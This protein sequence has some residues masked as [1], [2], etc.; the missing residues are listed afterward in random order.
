MG[1]GRGRPQK[2][3]DKEQFE[4]LCEIQCTQDEI[5]AFFDVTD[6]TLTRWCKQT[7]KMGFAETFRIK[8]KSGFISLRHAQYQALKEG[9]PTMLVWLGKQWLGQSEKPSADVAEP[10]IS[11]EIEAL[12][13]ELDEE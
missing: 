4:K 5:C 3:I 9:N 7:Y 1:I 11:D 13:A 2:E 12:L 8:R 6:K 10:E